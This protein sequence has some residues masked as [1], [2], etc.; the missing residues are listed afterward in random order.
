M[1][2]GLQNI[3]QVNWVKDC[4][5]IGNDCM[6]LQVIQKGHNQSIYPVTLFLLGKMIMIIGMPDG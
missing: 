6:V 4:G 1:V 5:V 3:S 2:H